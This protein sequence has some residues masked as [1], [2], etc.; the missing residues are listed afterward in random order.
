MTLRAKLM[1]A[2]LP[3]PL[4]AIIGLG[5]WHYNAA[6]KMVNQTTSL[7]LKTMLESYVHSE[8]LHRYNLLETLGATEISSFVNQ[9]Q[10]EAMKAADQ[11][12]AR[13]E[14]HL[15]IVSP[16]GQLLHTTE[17]PNSDEIRPGFKSQL[18]ICATSHRLQTL[19]RHSK[20]EQDII[21]ISKQ[22]KPW[23][24]IIILV[25]DGQ[26]IQTSLSKIRNSTLTV[27]LLVMAIIT[28][29]IIILIRKFILNPVDQLHSAATLIANKQQIQKI[30]VHSQ[31]ELGAL[32]RNM[33]K[34][35]HEIHLTH[36]RLEHHVQ[37]R[38]Q[39]LEQK[40]EL[41]NQEIETRKQVE[42]RLNASNRDLQDFAYVASHDLQEPLRM[43]SS[44]LQLISRRYQGKLDQDANEFINFAVD[45][46]HRMSA[47]IDGLLQYSRV[48]TQ[49]E[50]FNNTD[51][52]TIIKDVTANL[53][54][55]IEDCGAKIVAT[56][57]PVVYCDQNQIFRLLQNL[58][59]NALKFHGNA[60][61][62][63]NITAEKTKTGWQINVSDNGIGIAKKDQ[64][65][66]FT[67]FKRLH[68]RTKF[69][70]S[71]IG[72]AV[73]KRIVKRHGEVLRVESTH[74]KGSRFY[75]I[76]PFK[77]DITR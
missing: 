17:H 60:P 38:T 61:P 40:T 18:D 75:F 56:E 4:F 5:W 70:G 14:G 50:T 8:I 11:I 48:E 12:T 43:V 22:F 19:L 27:A 24:W 71:G 23:N 49:G 20:Q 7:Y 77:Q 73:C 63:I 55:Q 44:Y 51:M 39:E 74:G 58:L 13:Q 1:L 30:G 32:A 45:G 37:I 36:N 16:E 26:D 33:E 9:Y 31:D 46:A 59:T 28:I 69:P 10:Q 68:G 52:N 35:A 15:F 76:L 29:T 57:L 62:E 65:Q 6:I 64:Q 67:M 21:C 72:L 54:L 34:M 66:I 42:A 47:M 53:S 2:I 3:L 41:L 25:L